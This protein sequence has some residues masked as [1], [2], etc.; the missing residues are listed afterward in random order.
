MIEKHVHATVLS[1]LFRSIQQE[2]VDPARVQIMNRSFPT[3]IRDYLFEDNRFRGKPVDVAP[4]NDIIMGEK[5]SIKN[6]M[7]RV[8]HDHWPIEAGDEV[9]EGRLDE[10]ISH[11]VERLSSQISIIHQRMQWALITR[12]KLSEKERQVVKLDEM[13]RRILN[14]CRDYLDKLSENNLEN[15]TLNVLAREGFLPGYALSQG[16]VT[17]FVGRAYSSTWQRISFDLP[18]PSTIAVREFVPGNL[19]YANGGKYKAR[20]IDCQSTRNASTQTD[21]SS[22]SR[23]SRRMRRWRD[24]AIMPLIQC[25]ES[26]PYRSATWTSLSLHMFRMRS[27]TVSACR[28]L[29]L[30]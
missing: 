7:M 30:G 23:P 25:K 10:H 20:Y 11:T 14:R 16:N 15:Y 24:R 28:S 22:M 13:E 21:T 5:D 8:F 12:N 3:F 2:N 18:R 1:D 4:L 29:W 26:R 6:H 9:T 27:R 19:I 17:A